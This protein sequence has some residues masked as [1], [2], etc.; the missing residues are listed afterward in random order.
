MQPPESVVSWGRNHHGSRWQE[1]IVWGNQKSQLESARLL[2]YCVQFPM[3]CK[4]WVTHG[5]MII[6]IP[7]KRS[8][9]H[10]HYSLHENSSHLEC[11]KYNAVVWFVNMHQW[12]WVSQLCTNASRQLTNLIAPLTSSWAWM[13]WSP[14][15]QKWDPG[16]LTVILHS[17][18]KR[19]TPIH[20]RMTI[21]LNW[22][23]LRWVCRTEAQQER[24][25]SC[26][27]C[28]R[29]QEVTWGMLGNGPAAPLPL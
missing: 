17:T 27:V 29:H 25:I 9:S 8:E 14:I 21:I 24:F 11:Y 28:T 19:V 3:H 2:E 23:L 12:H 6:R 15:L 5:L 16:L 26:H 22:I 7:S 20:V 1:E 10:T 13:P 18:M 4:Q